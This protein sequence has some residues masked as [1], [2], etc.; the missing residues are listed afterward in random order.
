MKRIAVIMFAFGA[1]ILT[2]AMKPGEDRERPHYLKAIADLRD[3]RWWLSHQPANGDVQLDDERTAV[4]CIDDAIAE[5]KKEAIDDGKDINDHTKADDINQ[6]ESRLLK[7]NDYLTVAH[8]E[9][10]NGDKDYSHGL[11]G[12]LL[13]H[14]DQAK[15]AVDRALKLSRKK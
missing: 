8:K 4:K 2:G 15:A 9:I 14:I 13:T 5:C 3:A 11:K 1:F 7:A 10:E 6:R 12:R